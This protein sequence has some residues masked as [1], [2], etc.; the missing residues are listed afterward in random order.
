MVD[1]V[2]AV[3]GHLGR[4]GHTALV[5]ATH[6]TL[7]GHRFR[8]IT[9]DSGQESV[10]NVL[11]QV[12]ALEHAPL[13][14]VA[15]RFTDAELD[16]LAELGL[17]AA[18]ALG[19]AHVQHE[20]VHLDVRGRR[21]AP[22][23]RAEARPSTTTGR[24]RAGLAVTFVL[25]ADPTLPTAP[26][27]TLAAAA[28]VSLGTAQ[29]VVK[30]LRE[31]GRLTSAGLVDVPR[32]AQRWV[33]DYRRLPLEVLHQLHAPAG[34]WRDVTDDERQA[35]GV[36]W[37]GET[38]AELLRGYL[39]TSVGVAYV[40]RM[41][42][43]LAARFRMRA[44]RPSDAPVP[45]AEFR[46][47]LWGPDWPVVSDREDTVPPLLVYADLLRAEDGRL[48]EAAADLR[49]NDDALRRLLG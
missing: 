9:V 17:A 42:S 19:N 3:A 32:L 11:G 31:K 10:L 6:L 1:T 34:W 16:R 22:R 13:L 12:K 23:K 43:A 14:V 44:W 37:G 38:A 47:P 26:L 35:A 25:L 45:F 29:S 30:E 27:R 41:P 24:R 28:G 20:G 40:T 2:D 21:P 7:D 18:D 15:P 48:A 8:V 36:R 39:R 33:E 5:T 46:K 4:L 49:E